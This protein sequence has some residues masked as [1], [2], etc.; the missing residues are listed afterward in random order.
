[1]LCKT[2]F[3]DISFYPV[4]R[5]PYSYRASTVFTGVS[6]PTKASGNGSGTTSVNAEDPVL[7]DLLVIDYRYAK[8]ALDT[9]NGLFSAVK[10]VSPSWCWPSLF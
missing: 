6:V 8:F 9:N 3:G 7:G 5:I 10:C 4:R 2:T 1:M